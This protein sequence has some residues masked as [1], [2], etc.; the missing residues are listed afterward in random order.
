MQK[1]HNKKH[2]RLRKKQDY[3]MILKNVISY[4]LKKKKKEPNKNGSRVD[5]E[6]HKYNWYSILP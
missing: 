4:E 2:T 3:G 6:I 1:L 5:Q